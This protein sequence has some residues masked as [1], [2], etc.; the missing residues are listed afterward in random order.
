MVKALLQAPGIDVHLKDKVFENH[1]YY[2]LFVVLIFFIGVPFVG[3]ND[4][5]WFD[6]LQ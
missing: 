3:W 1:L 4:C 2:V 5:A 6:A